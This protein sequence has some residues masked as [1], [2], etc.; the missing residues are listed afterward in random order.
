MCCESTALSPWSADT[1]CNYHFI[2]L[3]P[4]ENCRKKSKTL[5]IIYSNCV[6]CPYLCHFVSYI[7]GS[8]NQTVARQYECPG[9]EPHIPGTHNYCRLMSSSQIEGNIMEAGSSNYSAKN[10]H[11]SYN[12][13]ST[14]Y[15]EQQRLSGNVPKFFL[16]IS[17]HI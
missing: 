12:A 17:K 3:S 16:I 1:C 5:P 15:T 13:D 8:S 14:S 2:N 6:K 10:K 7:L 4:L 11:S 9:Y